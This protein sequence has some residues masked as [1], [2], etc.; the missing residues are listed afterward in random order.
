MIIVGLGSSSFYLS[1]EFNK[2]K[3][4]TV[5][6]KANA[7][8]IEEQLKLVRKSA[9]TEKL[10]YEG[11]LLMRKAEYAWFPM[12]KI[13][14]FRQGKRKLET[15]IISDKKNG[16][17]RFLRLMI[18]ENVPGILNY[19]SHRVEDARFIQ[20]VYKD[21]SPEIQ[22]AVIGYRKQSKLLGLLQF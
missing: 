15:A 3:F 11:V 2:E 9:I 8:Q 6:A 12:E 17:L 13:S 1:S 18:Q 5:I 22:K 20:S 21:L 7:D 10:G 19:N 14:L 16:E 4:F